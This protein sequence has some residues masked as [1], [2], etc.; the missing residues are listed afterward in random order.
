MAVRT[1]GD[2]DPA[3][4][5]VSRAHAEA[6]YVIG[7]PFFL[8]NRMAL[9]KLASK[10]RLPVMSASRQ[11]ADAGALM[12]YGANLGDVFRRSAGYVEDPEGRETR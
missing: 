12:S 5:A 3:F 6:L 8:S 2:F 7:A 11:S 1:A 9:Q 10:A 4:S